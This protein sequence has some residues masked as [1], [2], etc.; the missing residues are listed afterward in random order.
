MK[1]VKIWRQWEEGAQMEGVEIWRPWEGIPQM[2]GVEIW[3]PQEVILGVEIWRSREEGT[4]IEGV[5]IQVVGPV[6]E[7]E[8]VEEAAQAEPQQQT[9]T[10]PEKVSAQEDTLLRHQGNL[11][12]R[13]KGH[14]RDCKETQYYSQYERD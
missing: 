11:D 13:H 3:R 6:V 7:G 8:E 12:H 4:Q 14:G 10:C 9:H 2:E 5:G 1:T